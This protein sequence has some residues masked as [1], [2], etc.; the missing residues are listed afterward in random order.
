MY[1]YLSSYI[2][3][4]AEENKQEELNTNTAKQFEIEKPADEMN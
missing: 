4:G 3:G 1:N 2:Y